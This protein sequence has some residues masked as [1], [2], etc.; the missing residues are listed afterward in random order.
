VNRRLPFADHQRRELGIA[1]VHQAGNQQLPAEAEQNLNAFP[2]KD[3]RGLPAVQ[4]PEQNDRR[5][6]TEQLLRDQ[7]PDARA[8]VRKIDAERAGNERRAERCDAE[9]S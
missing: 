5:D 7:R 6:R 1:R 3:E 9:L 4:Q 8:R 2:G